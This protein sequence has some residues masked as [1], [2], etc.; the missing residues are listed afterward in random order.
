VHAMIAFAKKTFGGL[1]FLV[2]NASYPYK[3]EG[4]FEYW[5]ETI[6]V[7]LTAPVLDTES[8]AEAGRE[9]DR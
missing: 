4:P 9:I 6:Q 5:V 8:D 3:P 1:D 2:N 7:D